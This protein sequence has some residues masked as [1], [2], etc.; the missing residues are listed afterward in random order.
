MSEFIAEHSLGFVIFI[1]LSL[2]LSPFRCLFA[3]VVTHILIFPSTM[4]QIILDILVVALKF[5]FHLSIA[6]AFRVDKAMGER[7]RLI[8]RQQRARENAVKWSVKESRFHFEFNASYDNIN[9][10]M[11]EFN[12]ASLH[13]NIIR[14]SFMLAQ[15]LTKT[16]TAINTQHTVHCYYCC[17]CDSLSGISLARLWLP[18]HCLRLSIDQLCM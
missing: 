15:V 6:S 1:M 3:Y 17:C 10:K 14:W 7:E 8:D 13:S 4:L 18:Q 9:R 11:Y 12:L 5:Q 16:R 2:C